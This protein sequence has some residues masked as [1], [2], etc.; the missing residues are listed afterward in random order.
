[1]NMGRADYVLWLASQVKVG[2]HARLAFTERKEEVAISIT[3]C[4]APWG[5][6]EGSTSCMPVLVE[7]WLR[8]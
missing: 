4:A 6:A 1:M 2:D 8:S 3:L 7:G 5:R